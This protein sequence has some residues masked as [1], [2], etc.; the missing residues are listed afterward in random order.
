M[1]QL[2]SK[3]KWVVHL[4]RPWFDM[5]TRVNFKGKECYPY[6]L[7]LSSLPATSLLLPPPRRSVSY[8]F[9]CY[10]FN[11]Y[12]IGKG[13][14]FHSPITTAPEKMTYSWGHLSRQRDKKL[15][16]ILSTAAA[17]IRA[18]HSSCAKGTL[19]MSCSLKPTRFSQII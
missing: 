19:R 3:S 16:S 1:F 9:A 17:V 18:L 8:L 11:V 4:K 6:V 15:R 10:L 7:L 5:L 14:Y 12:W 2:K 13:D